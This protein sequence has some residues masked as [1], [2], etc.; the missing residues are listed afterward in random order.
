DGIR[1]FHV[2]RVQTCALPIS[3]RTRRRTGREVLV[4]ADGS[5]VHGQ[6][7]ALERA[8]SNPVENAAKFDAEGTAPIEISIRGGRV[9]V[10]DRGRSEERR[11]GHGCRC[12]L[13]KYR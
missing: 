4:D 3:E 1:D 13:A 10:R 5:V 2:T 11:V 9:E 6:P 8:L 12:R 7:T